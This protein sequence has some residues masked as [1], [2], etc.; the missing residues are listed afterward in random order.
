MCV[1]GGGEDR[2]SVDL[3]LHLAAQRVDFG[4][5]LDLVVPPLDAYRC[6][7]LIG[8][9]DLDDV[10]AYA[11]GAAVKIDVIA[12]VLQ[13]D[14]PPQHGVALLFGAGLQLTAHLTVGLL[15]ADAEDAGD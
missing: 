15:R 12:F 9:K 14:E 6:V 3:A 7:R 4:D 5:R 13:I 8:R 1:M 11:K 2:R 10:A